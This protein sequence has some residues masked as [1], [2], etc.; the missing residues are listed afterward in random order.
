MTVLITGSE[1]LIGRHLSPRLASCGFRLKGFDI[2]RSMQED[3]RDS[4]ALTA[5]LDGAEGVVHLAAVSRVVWGELDPAT[6]IATN[7]TAVRRLF[8]AAIRAARR[9]WVVFMS[10]REV[11][12]DAAAL[13]VDEDAPLQPM[14][15][16][17]RSKRDGELLAREARD[18]GLVVNVGRLSSVYG[19]T[20]D[21]AD[22]VVP[23][24]AKAAA[25]GGSIRVEGHS[26]TLDFTFIDDIADGIAR[27]VAATARGEGYPPIHFVSGQ[28]TTLGALAE[29]AVSRARAPVESIESPS[30]DYDVSHFVGNPAR[31]RALLGWSATVPIA[32]GLERL[33]AGYAGSGSA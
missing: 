5:A 2:R 3:V 7:V 26:N 17:A 9:P 11:Y 8:D 10:S 4:H 23:A 16:Y 20:D 6:C 14:N 29:L 15:V 33:I 25:C 27:L 1:G 13:P 18:A 31:A 32:Q 21:H 28:A 19:C 22:R 30:R 24:F 12:G